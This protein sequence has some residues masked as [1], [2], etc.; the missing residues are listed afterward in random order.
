MPE[1]GKYIVIEGSDGTG[2]SLQAIRLTDRLESMGIKCLRVFNDETDRDEPIQ[3]PG[4]TPTANV[5]RAKIKNKDIA[6]TPWQN[7]EWFTEARESIWN[8]AIKPALDAGIT[9]ITSRSWIST[10]AYQGYGEGVPLD[11]IRDYTREH[12]GEEYMKPDLVLI[13]AMKDEVQRRE[14][15]TAAARNVSAD[16]DTFESMPA[17]FQA[18]M[19]SGYVSFAEDNGIPLTDASGMPDEVDALIWDQVQKIL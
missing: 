12:V 10:M 15:I 19:Q 11:D 18:N 16:K 2:K 3:E 8:E 1:R 9:V 14:R 5:I 13:L 6:R 4:G 17:E 7:V